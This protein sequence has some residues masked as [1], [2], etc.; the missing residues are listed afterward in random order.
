MHFLFAQWL[1]LFC[2]TQN[3]FFLSWKVSIIYM[4]EWLTLLISAIWIFTSKIFSS[5]FFSFHQQFD[6]TLRMWQSSCMHLKG[7]QVKEAISSGLIKH[8][9]TRKR[10]WCY[11]LPN[12]M[13]TWLL[14]ITSERLSQVKRLMYAAELTTKHFGGN[15]IKV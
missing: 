3:Y 1:S 2:F 10:S 8:I 4:I 7:R 13:S 5:P 6:L 14:I 11:P 15:K 9:S 12:Q